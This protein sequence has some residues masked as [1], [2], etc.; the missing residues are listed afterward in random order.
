MMP[1]RLFLLGP[2]VLYSPQGD[3]IRPR[4]RKHFG[5][6]IVLSVE[7]SRN[8]LRDELAELFWGDRPTKRAKH[9]LATAI[10]ELRSHLGSDAI[11][12]MG[13]SIRVRPGRIVNDLANLNAGDPV[14]RL[15]PYGQ[16][17]QGFE[18]DDAAGFQQ[19]KD[20]HAAHL[21]SLAARKLSTGIEAARRRG[22]ADQLHALAVQ[23]TAI[24]PYSESAIR[25][26]IESQAMLGDRLGAL[27]T[28]EHWR[29]HIHEELGALPSVDL[30]Q[31]AQRL[32]GNTITTP[33]VV[34]TRSER[35]G[36]PRAFIGR[37]AEF[38]SCRA[39]WDATRTG[40]TK[41]ILIR[42]ETGIGKSEL[43]NRFIGSISLE[44]VQIARV[45]GFELE[46]DLPFG[47]VSELVSRLIDLPGAGATAPEQLAELIRL[48]P[49]IR[50]RYMSLPEPKFAWSETSQIVLA[51]AIA[52]LLQ[53]IADEKPVVIVI[54]DLHAVDS[55]SIAICHM[56]F[57]RIATL[58]VMAMLTSS[59]A[60]HAESVDARRL[61]GDPV[62]IGLT[63]IDLGPLSTA[64]STTVLDM[65]TADGP[66]P[67]STMRRMMLTFACGNPMVLELLAL[68]WRHYG[69]R[70][71]AASLGAMV[72]ETDLPIRSSLQKLFAHVFDAIHHEDRAVAELAA[73]LGKRLNDLTM[74]N[75]LD[76]PAARAMRSISGLVAHRVLRDNGTTLEFSNE[77]VRS[78]FYV[79]MAAPLR[80]L[81]HGAVADR[82]I[83]ATA[84]D[85]SIPKL[86][87][88]WHLVRAN[89]LAE[90]V[91]YLIAGGKDAICQGAV[92]E[93]ETALSTGILRLCGQPRRTA[94]LLLAEAQQEL[95]RWEDALQ[96]L[97][98]SEEAFDPSECG[99]RDV[100]ATLSKRW[101]GQLSLP[102]AIAATDVL[103]GIAGENVDVETRVKALAGS[104][105]LLGLTRDT[106]QIAMLGDRVANLSAAPMDTFQQLHL[107]LA[108]GWY[109][110]A[111]G[112]TATA[113]AVIS[114]GVRLADE[115]NV[116][117]SIAVR[118]LIGQANLLYMCGRYLQAL[119]PLRR[120]FHACEQLGNHTLLGECACQ[121]ALVEG[122][123]GQ[124]DS[125]IG[126]ARK[127][128]ELLPQ[129]GWCTYS[130]SAH[131]ELGLGLVSEGRF[132]E[133]AVAVEPLRA[134]RLD[135]VPPW[136][137]QARLLCAAD[138]LELGGYS[139]R[140]FAA[141]RRATS[142][143]LSMPQNNSFA[144]PF[145]RWTALLGIRSSTERA[146]L[147]KLRTIFP[148]SSELDSK[149][150]AEL[151]ASVA[152]LEERLGRPTRAMWDSVHARLEQ[153]PPTISALMR[154]CGT[155]APNSKGGAK[156]DAEAS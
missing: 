110:S 65:M 41:N 141:A 128:L 94:I 147:Q 70:C 14:D 119:V 28:Y 83:A 24:D 38:A 4:T 137:V 20:A 10:V 108:Q 103:L 115:T 61:V 114:E 152:T 21:G 66:P 37:H 42:G 32:R 6:L 36:S 57:R 86:E 130:I 98:M 151:L 153:L 140:A 143:A 133:A 145:A 69:D 156:F 40:I 31:L 43:V 5:L 100:Y 90:A 95:G 84:V 92:H 131:Y 150:Q 18:I 97:E 55:T 124:S 9:S 82:L 60:L 135:G 116:L 22:D 67:S 148:N 91:P 122:R 19:W 136:V 149:D 39:A 106:R 17:L 88:A 105:R 58:P 27:R 45:K 112:D 144:G 111:Q 73:I 63:V 139:R 11:E 76:F 79:S 85:H 71:T 25:A 44:G 53:S 13:N 125:Q 2:P 104:V 59:N 113:L 87:I 102:G 107:I 12:G 146:A 118:L 120:A 129:N 62:G 101:L 35:D 138:V 72:A 46:R 56:V 80:G 3:L 155:C 75:L 34:A 23:L 132:E 50:Q 52:S 7:T 15:R 30:T 29:N 47:V 54:D 16:F 33:L 89:R 74:Y 51:E 49:R 127:A 99:C 142:G 96:M 121:L 77:C 26:Q 109:S 64:D 81:L 8:H 93:A 134:F 68:D 48:V 123:L 78:Q 1:F 154:S 117:S 126:W